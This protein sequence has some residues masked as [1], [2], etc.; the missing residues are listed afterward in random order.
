[1]KEKKKTQ[2]KSPNIAVIVGVVLVLLIL[3]AVSMRNRKKQWGMVKDEVKQEMR[4]MQ[5]E[6][7]DELGSDLG[8]KKIWENRKGDFHCYYE[9]KDE[10]A[11]GLENYRMD[12]YFADDELALFVDSAGHKMTSIIMEDYTYTWA[13]DSKEGYKMVTEEEDWEEDIEEDFV[14]YESDDNL[15]EIDAFSPG[16][17]K[18]EKW[19]RDNKVFEIPTDIN[20]VEMGS[21]MEDMEDMAEQMEAGEMDMEDFAEQMQMYGMEQ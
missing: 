16:D 8:I 7:R 4:G 17:F 2:K 21:Y 9:Y 6:I 20:F 15:E 10:S 5:Q 12:Y 19:R 1:M 14:D 3:G 11:D 18:C 13:N